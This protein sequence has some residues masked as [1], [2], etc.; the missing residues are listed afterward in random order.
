[1]YGLQMSLTNIALTALIRE[2]AVLIS[3]AVNAANT[4]PKTPGAQRKFAA[5]TKAS[6]GS[7]VSS[8]LLTSALAIQ[9]P[10]LVAIA[11]N[12]ASTSI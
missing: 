3:A 7:V 9:P 1:M 2:S 6:P 8:P 10:Q 12:G 5:F 4:K 11:A